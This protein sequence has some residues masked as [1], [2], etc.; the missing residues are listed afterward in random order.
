M[1]FFSRKSAVMS[2]EDLCL[3]L[4]GMKCYLIQESSV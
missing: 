3:G 1:N 4:D 2:W